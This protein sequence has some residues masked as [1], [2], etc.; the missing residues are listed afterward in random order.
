MLRL[1]RRQVIGRN[2]SLLLRHG[3][4]W[5]RTDPY[6]RLESDGTIP[7][8]I[9]FQFFII[10]AHECTLADI[11]QIVAADNREYQRTHRSDRW[12][13]VRDANNLIVRIGAASGHS[14]EGRARIAQDGNDMYGPA[15]TK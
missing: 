12:K 3:K 15:L 13:T 9:L 1:D 7:V 10:A 5:I 6:L 2:M 4:G 11:E 8:E 14:D